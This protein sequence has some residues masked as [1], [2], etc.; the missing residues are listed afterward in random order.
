[1]KNIITLILIALVFSVNAQTKSGNKSAPLTPASPESVGM[2]SERLARIDV[3][4][5]EVVRSGDLPGI[6]A[7]VARNG[8]IV[9]H[10][11]YGMA[12]NSS[13]R[14]MKTDDI[15]RIASQYAD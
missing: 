5:E 4:C 9:F 7:L 1:M 14:K 6:V 13:G 11:A 8:K 12:D 3:M 15:F 2:S 10:Q